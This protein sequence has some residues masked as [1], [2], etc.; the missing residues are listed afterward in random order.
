[1]LAQALVLLTLAAI[2]LPAPDGRKTSAEFRAA[3]GE[4]AAPAAILVPPPGTA[5]DASWDKLAAAL[6]EAGISTLTL[7]PRALAAG[8]AFGVGA[9]DVT[10][11]L[12]WLRSRKGVDATKLVVVGAGEGA[13]VALAGSCLDTEIAG[14]ALLSPR[15]D[16]ERLDD[17]TAMG[18]WGRRPVFVAVAKGDKNAARSALVLDGN[19]KGP[20]EL[21]IGDGSRQGAALLVHDERART[22]FLRWAR[23]TTG[24]DAAAAD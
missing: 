13:M 22:A 16:P 20:K 24:I 5:A 12:G 9:L 7:Q 23:V 19:A 14:L 8:D 3:S 21:V 10:G 4:G 6:N 1:M 15:L 17:A 18:D 11:A 2:T